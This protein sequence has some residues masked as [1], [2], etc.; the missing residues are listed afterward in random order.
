MESGKHSLAIA[1]AIK[2]KAKK[3]ADGGRVPE[4][5]KKKAKEM[6]DGATKSGWQPKEWLANAKSAWKAEGGLVEDEDMAR[7]I[8]LP[9]MF[10][11]DKEEQ[12]AKHQWLPLEKQGAFM[13]KG[14]MA[15][16][17]IIAI[18]I[19]GKKMAEGGKAGPSKD[20]FNDKMGEISKGFDKGLNEGVIAK[21]KKNILG[22]GKA[23]GGMIDEDESL[24]NQHSDDHPDND[25]LSGEED[26]SYWNPNQADLKEGDAK[27]RRKAMIASIMRK[28]S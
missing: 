26:S 18:K 13:S 23:E 19:M 24:D 9:P 10:G 22:K 21:F 1:Y 5:D 6:Q 12:I 25:W 14:G 28:I 16:P 17:K 20:D 8:D 11:E 7:E 4:P 3:M 2:R 27:A 15:D